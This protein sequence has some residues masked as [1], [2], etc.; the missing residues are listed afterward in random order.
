MYVWLNR[1]WAVTFVATLSV[2]EQS[3]PK[4]NT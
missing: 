4:I 1:T 2:H 3:K